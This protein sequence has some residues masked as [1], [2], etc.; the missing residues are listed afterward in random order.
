MKFWIPIVILQWEVP[1]IK[2]PASIFRSQLLGSILRSP[3][4]SYSL[5]SLREGYIG[6]NIGLR[7]ILGV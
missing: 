2:G 5:N 6:D 1:N 3:H 7:G 4:M